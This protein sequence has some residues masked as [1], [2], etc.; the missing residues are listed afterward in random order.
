ME[1]A[2]GGTELCLANLCF[3]LCWNI[4]GTLTIGD[5]HS[6]SIFPIVHQRAKRIV[7][8]AKKITKLM[9]RNIP[10]LACHFR[11]FQLSASGMSVFLVTALLLSDQEVWIYQNVI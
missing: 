1:I 7:H 6:I 8:S 9:E 3:H 5:V 2:S 11:G 10:Y 4:F